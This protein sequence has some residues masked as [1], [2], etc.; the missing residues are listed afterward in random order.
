MD[1]G[2]STI[3][4][5]LIDLNSGKLMSTSAAVNP[6]ISHGEDIIRRITYCMENQNGLDK[7]NEL[8][9]AALN[10]I[11]DKACSNANV[12]PEEIYELTIVGN[13]AMHHFF[14][15]LDSKFLGLSPFT[16][17]VKKG[18]DIKARELGLKVKPGTNVHV[19]PVIGGFVGAD[20][21]GVILST[22]LYNEPELTL[23]IDIGTNGEIVLGNKEH[24]EVCSCA[25]GPAFEGGHLKH[26]MRGTE[27]AVEKVT[28]EPDTLDVMYET[29]GDVPARGVCGSGVVD[30]VAELFKAGVVLR[31]G[32]ISDV[33]NPRIRKSD[34]GLEF[35]LAWSDETEENVGDIVITQKDIRE[36]QLAKAAL[37]AGA[38][39]LMKRR[40]I[41]ERDI[42]RVYLAGAFGSYVDKWSAKII[43]LYPDIP[44]DR[45]KSVGN[46]AGA[47][48]RQVLISS[49]RRRDAEIIAKNAHYLELTVVSEFQNEFLSA[50]YFPHSYINKFSTIRNLCKNSM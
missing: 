12:K 48:A 21:V 34:N 29:I 49:E 11:I 1:V 38:S 9:I 18:V 33:K 28:I 35:V 23:A 4:G 14:L 45:V 27:G 17:V 7:L 19:L 6:Q 37:Y 44:L 20:T 24:I 50:M 41:L 32:Q 13:T 30:A 16:P 39:I 31:T 8:V 36:I 3:V 46:A 22:N 26:G 25:A 2:T 43:G 40:G 10:D 15:K 42:D 47:G 5:Y